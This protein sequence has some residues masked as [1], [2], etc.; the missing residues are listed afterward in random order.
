M[1]SVITMNEKVQKELNFTSW[2]TCLIFLIIGAI[3][4]VVY[5]VLGTIGIENYLVEMLLLIYA[6][7]F[8]F[9]LVFLIHINKT[10]KTN[11]NLG[12]VVEYELFKDYMTYRTLRNGEERETGK[13]LYKDSVKLKET[14]SY[15]F[16]YQ[17]K[18]SAYPI[19][20][21]TLSEVDLK[22]LKDYIGL[23]NKK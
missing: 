4:L 18:V 11:P 8:G 16:L 9:G 12:I 22:I 5:V 1:K 13:F 3:G 17:T 7:L 14:K 19:Q 23:K 15:I 2:L 10:N 6:I 20:K 21:D